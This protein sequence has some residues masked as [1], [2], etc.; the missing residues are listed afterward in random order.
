MSNSEPT[1]IGKVPGFARAQFLDGLA[2]RRRCTAH[3]AG[4]YRA[5]TRHLG[6]AVYLYDRI[7]TLEEQTDA[8]Q[9]ALPV[10]A[11]SADRI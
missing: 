8:M 5:R 9:R 3:D 7:D 10:I 11:K 4:Y 6:G 2:P 1:I